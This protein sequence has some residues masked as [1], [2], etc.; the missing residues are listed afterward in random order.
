MFKLTNTN[1]VLKDNSEWMSLDNQE[2]LAWL[3]E[4]NTPDPADPVSPNELILQQIALLEKSQS[5]RRLRE[6]VLTEA[7]KTWLADV[8]SQITELRKG[9]V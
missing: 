8:D 9:L 2:Y 3:A 5:D 6:A 1:S 4:G 7:G